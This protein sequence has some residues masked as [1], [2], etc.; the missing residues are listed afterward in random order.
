MYDGCKTILLQYV[1]INWCKL[2]EDGDCA[3]TCRSK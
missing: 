1:L 2:S 3:E